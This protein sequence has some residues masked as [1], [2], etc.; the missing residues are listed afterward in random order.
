MKPYFSILAIT[1]LLVTGLTVN[2]QTTM[3]PE[4]PPATSQP[5][6]EAT[7]ATPTRYRVDNIR[8]YR[9]DRQSGNFAKV[10]MAQSAVTSAPQGTGSETL[11]LVEVSGP[12]MADPTTES[13]RLEM[14]AIESLAPNRQKKTIETAQLAFNKQN[15]KY[16]LP[17]VLYNTGCSPIQL[18]AR[19]IGQ[20]QAP[21]MEKTI[22]YQCK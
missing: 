10:D 22:Q 2:A 3:M 1:G 5:A 15:G 21:Q 13:G 4:Q 8:A 18:S 16:Y 9:F 12:A 14:T 6:M 7:A 20:E 11:V 17:F 19:I